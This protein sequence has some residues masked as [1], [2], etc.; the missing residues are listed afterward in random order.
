VRGGAVGEPEFIEH[1]GRLRA[2][3]KLHAA[4][5]GLLGHKRVELLAVDTSFSTHGLDGRE[6]SGRHPVVGLRRH[7]AQ[8]RGTV[9]CQLGRRFQ[10]QRTPQTGFMSPQRFPRLFVARRAFPLPARTREPVPLA[11]IFGEVLARLATSPEAV[12]FGAHAVN[13]YCEPERMTAD[14]DVLSTDAAGLAERL[15]AALADTFHI[16]ARVRAVAAGSFRVYQVRAPK[17]RHLVDVR[18]VERLPPYRTVEGVQVIEPA[19]LAAMKAL[20]M[21]ARG[22]QEKGLSDRLDLHRLVRAFPDLRIDEGVVAE[23]MRAL[24]ASE[25]ALAAWREVVA[26]PLS[27]DDDEG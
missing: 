24:G 7:L 18:Q 1:G 20:S 6:L 21:T 19:D 17:N 3:Q 13:A 5:A 4:L 23:R 9:R 10:W 15:R 22:G 14:I 25:P 11:A 8:P 16:A 26:R 12:V 27:A 2:G